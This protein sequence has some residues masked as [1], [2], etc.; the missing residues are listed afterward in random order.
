MT[1]GV[2]ASVMPKIRI[3]KRRLQGKRS[4]HRGGRKGKNKNIWIEK[5]DLHD[6]TSTERDH[7]LLRALEAEA[8]SQLKRDQAAELAAMGSSISTSDR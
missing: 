7:F 3:T 4:K 5:P 1:P 8:K 6:M 2:E